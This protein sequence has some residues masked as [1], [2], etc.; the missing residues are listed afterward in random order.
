M[1][2]IQLTEE[3]TDYFASFVDLTM[4]LMFANHWMFY[5]Q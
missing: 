1:P 2:P 5:F 4:F 3:L